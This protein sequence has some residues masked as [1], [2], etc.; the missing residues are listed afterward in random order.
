MLALRF[1]HDSK[2]GPSEY[3]MGLKVLSYTCYLGI[4]FGDDFY[5]VLMKNKQAE[6]NQI[7]RN[8]AS[9]EISMRLL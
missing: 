2:K 8:F 5:I 3:S 4:F 7:A 1:M 6:N 9:F